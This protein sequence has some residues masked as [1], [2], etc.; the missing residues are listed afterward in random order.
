MSVWAGHK[1]IVPLRLE[2]TSDLATVNTLNINTLTVNCIIITCM[3][4]E[5]WLVTPLGAHNLHV[6]LDA[7]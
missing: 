2:V 4:M 1:R 6:W 3:R 7:E 5:Y